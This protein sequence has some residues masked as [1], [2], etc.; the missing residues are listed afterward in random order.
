[1][2]ADSSRQAVGGFFFELSPTFIIPLSIFVSYRP[3]YIV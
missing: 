3:L 2:R 1:M